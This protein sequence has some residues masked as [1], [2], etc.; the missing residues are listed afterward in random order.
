VGLLWEH[1]YK[2]VHSTECTADYLYH[3]RS[4][5]YGALETGHR[6]RKIITERKKK[7][8]EREREREKKTQQQQQK[9]KEEEVE[10]EE[11]EEF[12]I[13]SISLRE[14]VVEKEANS[15]RFCLC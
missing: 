3:F 8:R 7:L 10:E 14:F 15:I 5:N 4:S 13:M 2:L 11:E 12:I 6:T 1:L 9:E